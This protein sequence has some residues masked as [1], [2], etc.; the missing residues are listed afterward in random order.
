[1]SQIGVEISL[2]GTEKPTKIISKGEYRGEIVDV[3]GDGWCTG[4]R[5]EPVDHYGEPT[6]FLM[7]SECFGIAF[8]PP[9]DLQE[10]PKG[11]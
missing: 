5:L 2:A 3:A 9:D 7:C 8:K 6:E 1:V 4:H 10:R 11:T